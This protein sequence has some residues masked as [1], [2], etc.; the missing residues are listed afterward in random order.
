MHLVSRTYARRLQLT[1]KRSFDVFDVEILA[2]HECDLRPASCLRRI[3]SLSMNC[4]ETR[5]ARRS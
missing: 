2:D 1:D 4:S 5:L 3:A